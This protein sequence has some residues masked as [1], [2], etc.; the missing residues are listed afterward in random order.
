MRKLRDPRLFYR[1]DKR[2]RFIQCHLTGGLKES[3]RCSSEKAAIAYV[4]RREREIADPRL[5][6]A[7]TTTLGDGAIA[8]DAELRR[9]GRSDATLSRLRFKLAH[10]M[11]ILGK[12]MPLGRITRELHDDYLDAR[13]KEGASRM[14]LRDEMAFLRQLLKLQI[15]RGKFALT[16]EQILPSPWETG[17]EPVRRTITIEQAWALIGACVKVKK[18]PSSDLRRRERWAP[19]ARLAWHLGSLGRLSE[20]VRAERCDINLCTDASGRV[21]GVNGNEVDLAPMTIYVRGSKTDAAA[22]VIP[23]TALMHPFLTFALAHAP[24][25]D[26]GPM[27]DAWSKIDRDMKRA[28]RKLGLPPLSANDL[29]RSAATWHVQAGVP[30]ELVAKLLRHTT[31]KLVQTTY[32]RTTATDIGR[33]IAAEIGGHD[34]GRDD[35]GD[36]STFRN[37]AEGSQGRPGTDRNSLSIGSAAVRAEAGSEVAHEVAT[38]GT[39]APLHD[40]RASENE[41][42]NQ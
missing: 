39:P 9:R 6:A 11:R 41:G 42:T 40:A 2:S 15:A 28:C 37:G 36:R 20:G 31:D 7:N 38:S 12:D 23:V 27:F 19:S 17:H 30:N 10:Y 29:R 3:T 4:N 25:G 33:L 21:W 26:A 8:L 16:I 24:G 22:D 1:A 34:A 18:G 14:L 35:S 13:L 5:A 32:G